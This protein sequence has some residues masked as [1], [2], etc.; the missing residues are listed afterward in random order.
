MKRNLVVIRF[1]RTQVLPKEVEMVAQSIVSQ[2]DADLAIGAP[3]HDMGLVSIFRT[4][5]TPAEVARLYEQLAAETGDVLPVIVM[6]LDSSGVGVHLSDVPNFT[7][8]VRDFQE[9]LAQAG[10]DA[11]PSTETVQVNMSLDDLL[12]LANR[13]GGVDQLNTE[14]RAL[15]EKLSKD[16]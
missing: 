10:G 6:D 7:R 3:F 9:K 2:E 12:D 16:L 14:E 8:L 15:L 4:S 13:K 11:E 5:C 1:G